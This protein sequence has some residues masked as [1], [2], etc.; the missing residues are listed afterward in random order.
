MR[1][2]P[3]V[4]RVG[5]LVV[6][7]LGVAGC[8]G[9]PQ[10]SSGTSLWGEPSDGEPAPPPGLFSWWHR[11]ASQTGAPSSDSAGLAETS[12]P[13]AAPA[14]ASRAATDPW[15]ESQSEW[16]ARSFPRMNRLWNGNTAGSARIGGDLTG[17]LQPGRAPANDAPVTASTPRSDVDVRPTDGATQ[18]AAASSADRP[19]ARAQYPNDLPYSQTPPPMRSPRQSMP[20]PASDPALDVTTPNS[21]GRR[22]AQSDE[23]DRAEP[24]SWQQDDPASAKGSPGAAS[25]AST[26]P[27]QSVAAPHALGDIL[28]APALAGSQAALAADRGEG[29]AT[30]ASAGTAGAAGSTSDPVPAPTADSRL[31]QVPPAPPPVRR[32]PATPAPATPAQAAPAPAAGDRPA[33]T[34]PEPPAAAAGSSPAPETG[35]APTPAPAAPTA[36]ATAPAAA[37]SQAPPAGSVQKP[38]AAS[39]QSL[40]A[41]PPPMAPAQPRHHLLSWLFHDEASGP[42]ASSQLP[43]A[44][45]PTT[46]SS[47]QQ[48]QPAGQ[49]NAAGCESPHKAPKKPC[50][51]KVWIHDLKNGGHCSHGDGC[52]KGGVCASPQGDANEC[53][54]HAKAP[55]KPCFL[56]VWIHEWKNGGHGS[57]CGGCHQGGNSNCCKACKCCGGGGTQVAA[58]PQG[59]V[60]SHQGG[61]TGAAAQ[62]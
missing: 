5:L 17:R 1:R 4:V 43:P 40:Y 36:A 15:P 8:A 29:A 13:N 2:P 37:Q 32:P 21:A 62:H 50:F 51:L 9:F 49:A 26:S 3:E 57:G 16:F 45:F 19:G 28:P 39:G 59:G 58:S 53:A 23:T 24:A 41:S 18:D 27:D 11:P 61:T 55:K 47:L 60:A 6:S 42:L 12:R 34:P 33:S 20:E 22:S 25:G 44:A 56:K 7:L 14:V 48:V 52:G 31:A 38:M 46:Y 35:Q 10:R 54:V 30:E